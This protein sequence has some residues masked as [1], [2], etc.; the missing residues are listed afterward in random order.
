MF[1]I[2]GTVNR[3]K[4]PIHFEVMACLLVVGLGLLGVTGYY[5]YLR[6]TTAGDLRPVMEAM[7]ALSLAPH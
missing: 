5:A 6:S 7:I 1:N 3:N 4:I 2:C